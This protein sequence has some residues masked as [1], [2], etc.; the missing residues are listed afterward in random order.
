MGLKKPKEMSY[1]EVNALALRLFRELEVAEESMSDMYRTVQDAIHTEERT[2]KSPH[3]DE[4]SK[5][6]ARERSFVLR[7]LFTRYN[8]L[9]TKLSRLRDVLSDLKGDFRERAASQWLRVEH[10]LSLTNLDSL[11]RDPVTGSHVNS[12]FSGWENADSQEENIFNETRLYD[13]LGKDDARTVLALW[14]RFHEMRVMRKRIDFEDDTSSAIEPREV[15]FLFRESELFQ[16]MED[17]LDFSKSILPKLMVNPEK[18]DKHTEP[19]LKNIQRQLG[20]L[21]E[22]LKRVKGKGK[23]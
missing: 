19:Q 1:D 11:H 21:F 16:K 22:R 12:T 2:I 20:D 8:N 10:F 7:N 15:M 13:A 6:Q 23:K 4:T 18:A 9:P 3:M 17:M 5:K 14:R